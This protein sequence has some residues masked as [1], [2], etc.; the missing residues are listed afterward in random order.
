MKLWIVSDLHLEVR[1]D[2][3]PGKRRPDDFDVFVLAGDVMEGDVVKGVEA[4]AAMAGGRPAIFVPGNHCHW[5]SSFEKVLEQGQ[6]AALRTGV[7]FLQNAATEIDGL[8]FFGAT[9]WDPMLPDPRASRPDLSAIMSGL[10]PDPQPH[11]ALPYGEPVHVQGPG[12]MDRR[13]KN[14]DVR[15]QFEIAR[16]AMK[17]VGADVVVTHYPPTADLLREIAPRYWVHGH[18]H[19]VRDETLGAT[20]VLA[21]AVGMVSENRRADNLCTM[22]VDVEPR[23]Q[24]PPPAP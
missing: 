4:A 10:E 23:P 16:D 13:A 14:R 12:V 21:N 17:N 22:V 5:G 18:E 15:R 11:S 6:E 3:V 7:R 20:R 9:L 19:R 1:R 8:V 2:F 24:P